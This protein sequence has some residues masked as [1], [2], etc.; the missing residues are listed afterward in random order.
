MAELTRIAQTLLDYAT[1]SAKRQWAKEVRLVHLLA[2]VRKW[3]E[4]WF[5]EQF[6]K[7]HAQLDDCL[8]STLGDAMRPES[9]D[10]QVE[11]RLGKIGKE[12]DIKKLAMDLYEALRD[13]LEKAVEPS[14][15]TA[16]E[17]AG[18]AHRARRQDSED[19]PKDV[20]RE[21][22]TADAMPLMLNRELAS[23][24]SDVLNED[25]SIV[26]SQLATHALAIARRVLGVDRVEIAEALGESLGVD[27]LSEIPGFSLD[28]LNA[29]VSGGS[30]AASRLATQ[31]AL[32]YVDVAEFAASLDKVVTDI[33]IE[34]ID[35][36]R[37]ETRE[38]LGDRIDAT[39]D[40]I[41]EFEARF[42]ELVGMESV[43]NDLRK[44]VEFM[45]VNKRKIARGEI[46]S[47]HRMHMAFVGNPGTGKT[48]VARL[49]GQLLKKLDLLKTAAFVE[50]DRSTLVADHVGGTE[51]RTR[52]A[53]KKANGGV[54]FVDEAYAL[55]D[56][57]FRQK[58]FGEEA[59]DVLVKAMEDMRENLAVV[60]AGY[61]DRMNEFLDINPGLKS[62]I[63]A[64]IQFP[65]YTTDELVE[66]AQRIATTRKLR[67]DDA[68]VSVLRETFERL[69]MDPSFGNAREVENVV[70]AAQR[71]LTTRLA[72]KGNLATSKESTLVLDIDI[73]A[74]H[75]PKQKQPIGFRR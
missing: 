21:T 17:D 35:A 57:Y 43:K 11:E 6:P 15:A 36:I 52:D 33:E 16:T 13:E 66:I 55:N 27:S 7:A 50:T 74:S 68:A 39:S 70:D 51:K 8:S 34:A 42:G 48:T 45:L 38:V 19:E 60:F 75:V 23:R 47:V 53:L 24:I 1:T 72:P 29:V 46:G 59:V 67:F 20:D 58:G 14:D 10:S 73:P 54:L 65:D 30:P 5:D 26:K 56:G 40:A 25:H 62:R 4:D 9:V 63:P 18:V 3:D 61:T 37:L 69:K 2:A 41:I 64:V 22:P 12:S 71:S 44:R 28:L 49:F 32:A 31:L